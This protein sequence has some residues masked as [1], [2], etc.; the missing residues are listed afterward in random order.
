MMKQFKR[1]IGVAIVNGNAKHKLGRLHYVISTVGKVAYICWAS[2]NTHQWKASQ[3]GQATWFSEH[4]PECYCTFEQ[5]WN[6][7]DFC[8]H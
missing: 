5:F 2:H 8:V 3:N 6:V 7:Y 4:V 1:A